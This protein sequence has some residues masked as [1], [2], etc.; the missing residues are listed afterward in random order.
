MI[1]LSGPY[2]KKFLRE[3]KSVRKRRSMVKHIKGYVR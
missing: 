1:A 3:K 2:V